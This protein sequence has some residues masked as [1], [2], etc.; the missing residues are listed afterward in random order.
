MGSFSHLLRSIFTSENSTIR[1]KSRFENK[2]STNQLKK[3]EN[4]IANLHPQEVS[5]SQIQKRL[6]QT[7]YDSDK[8]AE[9]KIEEILNYSRLSL[10]IPFI[11]I[12]L[13]IFFTI[14]TDST[15]K[16]VI[17]FS[18]T[19]GDT[20]GGLTAPFLTVL[21]SILIYKSFQEQ[22]KANKMQLQ[23]I[24]LQDETNIKQEKQR[25]QQES[26]A[27]FRNYLD[28]T[29][30]MKKELQEGFLEL[31]ISAQTINEK[32]FKG[33][34]FIKNLNYILD[35]LIDNYNLKTFK[36][37]IHDLNFLNTKLDENGIHSFFTIRKIPKPE[38]EMELICIYH[39]YLKHFYKIENQD[40]V[41]VSVLNTYH[42]TIST[43]FQNIEIIIE[44][45]YNEEGKLNEKYFK[46]F[47]LSLYYD[48]IALL[49]KLTTFIDNQKI[50]EVIVKLNSDV[51]LNIVKIL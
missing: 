35:I 38:A 5:V 37:E 45:C 16:D 41:I 3:T 34:D 13:G 29:I 39:S 18:G 12:V 4:N 42:A 47:E 51:P 6:E 21:G 46:S 32:D 27:D 31:D 49:K 14:S 40:K 10:V 15:F 19:L 43:Y 44:K 33:V 20:F 48:E 25:L 2:I 28:I 26:D 11:G 7:I 30:S 9:N 50:I 23:A 8:Q 36:I 17:A 24:N 1:S 22:V